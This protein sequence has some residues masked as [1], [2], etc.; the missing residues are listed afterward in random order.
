MGRLQNSIVR[1]YP[2]DKV[3]EDWQGTYM[4]YRPFSYNELQELRDMKVSP[5]VQAAI[6]RGAS[7]EEI[8][9]LASATEVDG[10]KK[11]IDLIKDHF[12]DGKVMINGKLED[13][14]K[15]D[16]G[17]L[18]SDV[19]VDFLSTLRGAQTKR[20]LIICAKRSF[21]VLKKYLKKS[22]T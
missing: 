15:D 13:M 21:R 16:V 22:Q 11:V 6:D 1:K 14:A 12:I 4:K 7:D 5:E 8:E 20:P 19:L 10:V 3:G 17:D 2:L 9:K 18:P